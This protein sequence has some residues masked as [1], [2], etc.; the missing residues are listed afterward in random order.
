MSEIMSWSVISASF[1]QLGRALCEDAILQDYLATIYRLEEAYG[2]ARTTRI[3]EELEVTP[4]TA[5]KMLAKFEKMGLV[6]RDKYKG[7]RL[8]EE[9]RRIAI[10]TVWKH[11]VCEYFLKVFFD[12]SSSKLHIYAH[13][14]EHLPEEV[15]ARMYE[16]AGRPSQC[17]HGNPIPGTSHEDNARPLTEF[18]AGQWVQVRRIVGEFRSVLEFLERENIDIG[19][20]MQILKVSQHSVVVMLT[21]GRVV[22]I[23]SDYAFLVR[24]V[25]I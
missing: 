18:S 9:G 13:I 4:A 17:P 6:E 10:R 15:I 3:A 19:T 20:S 2:I 8:T 22:R 25:K 21:N 11:R 16:L 23:P 7:A 5:A 14:M 12:L 1:R 24:A